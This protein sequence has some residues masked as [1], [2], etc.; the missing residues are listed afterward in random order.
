MNRLSEE[1][2]AATASATTRF[3]ARTS[4]RFRNIFKPHRSTSTGSP[5]TL[6]KSPPATAMSEDVFQSDRE[7]FHTGTDEHSGAFK[8]TSAGFVRFPVTEPVVVHHLSTDF[9]LGAEAEVE[10]VGVLSTSTPVQGESRSVPSHN[11]Y[12]QADIPGDLLSIPDV[13]SGQKSF[14]FNIFD[15]QDSLSAGIREYVE[16][17]IAEVFHRHSCACLVRAPL[18]ITANF[19]LDNGGELSHSSFKRVPT[20]RNILHGSKHIG[21]YVLEHSPN[22]YHLQKG[23]A[24]I[25]LFIIMFAALIGPKTFA[26]IIW[27]LSVALITYFVTGRL[28]GWQDKAQPDLLLAPAL[29]AAGVLYNIFCDAVAQYGIFKVHLNSQ[30]MR[31]SLAE[32]G[33]VLDPKGSRPEV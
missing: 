30:I 28:P 20:N 11:E 25:S 19:E 15:D 33:V 1:H 10:S 32:V 3:S 9:K 16:S 27:R 31:E 21:P 18:N 8:S 13:R 4:G 22:T 26:L 5:K 6:L 12:L 29:Y 7:S 2:H 23:I 17:K 14:A 24:A